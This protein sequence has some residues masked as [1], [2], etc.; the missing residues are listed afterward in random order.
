MVSAS[1][2]IPRSGEEVWAELERLEDHPA[3]MGDAESVA[4]LRE[5]RRGVGTRV[6]VATRVGPF[7]N[8]DVI[9][10][11]VWN[12]PARMVVVHRGLFTG[13]GE[14]R[15]A[16]EGEGTRVVWGETIRFPWYLGGPIGAAAVRPLL[17][18]V[19]R[20]NLENLSARLMP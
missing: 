4:F 14:F 10:F 20:R 15:L 13:T 3:W 8:K 17:R 18:R 11:V 5:R 1:T 7:R 9:E 12:P 6:E 2:F 16:P 19:F